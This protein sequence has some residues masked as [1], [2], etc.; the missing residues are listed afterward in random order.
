MPNRHQAVLS[1]PGS[2]HLRVARPS[3][4]CFPEARSHGRLAWSVVPADP[5]PDESCQ[6]RQ[7]AEERDRDENRE[8]DHVSPFHGKTRR[9]RV[10]EQPL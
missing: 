1:S 6:Q 4:R 2:T 9:R 5:P 10:P 3:S 8:D 7:D